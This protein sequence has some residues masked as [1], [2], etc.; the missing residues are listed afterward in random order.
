M[1]SLGILCSWCHARV[2]QP[3]A[4]SICQID[5]GK[6]GGDQA[7]GA[8]GQMADLRVADLTLIETH[9]WP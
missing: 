7:T 3:R 8:N 6:S 2:F 1:W 9:R 4:V 5:P